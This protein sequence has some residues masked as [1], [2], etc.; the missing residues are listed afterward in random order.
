MFN[1]KTDLLKVFVA[2]SVVAHIGVIG[3]GHFYSPKAQYAVEQAPNRLEVFII[4]EVKQ[5][6]PK[7]KPDEEVITVKDP[8]DAS[9]EVVQGEEIKIEEPIEE[10]EEKEVVEEKEVEKE[11]EAIVQTPQQ[12]A[13]DEAKPDALKNRAPK[14]PK[15]ARLNNW[16][17]TVVISVKVGVTGLAVEVKVKKSS[18]HR[19]LDQS[20][21]RT[22]KKW[23]F[24]PAHV[25]GLAIASTIEI[26]VKFVL[27]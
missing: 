23:K 20:A 7:I 2:A 16:E 1:Y 4:E 17:G 8:I 19:V 25:G 24:L 3:W 21:V 9:P 15:I 6:V 11:Q 26:P 5:K 18:G 10:I 22:V 14:Y 13:L 27:E 12:G